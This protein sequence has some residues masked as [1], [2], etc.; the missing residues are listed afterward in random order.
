MNAHRP[1]RLGPAGFFCV[2]DSPGVELTSTG[3][4]P[5]SAR[6]SLAM[7][8]ASLT[9]SFSRLNCP[10]SP[11]SVDVRLKVF[12]EVVTP[13]GLVPLGAGDLDIPV[14]RL[15]GLDAFFSGTFSGSALPARP[16]R[17]MA[18][19][20]FEYLR[21][22]YPP[23]AINAPHVPVLEPP[24]RTTLIPSA[25]NALPRCT[26]PQPNHSKPEGEPF[27]ELT[28]R[29]PTVSLR[30]PSSPPPPTMSHVVVS[31]THPAAF[32]LGAGV[33]PAGLSRC[34]VIVIE[35]RHHVSSVGSP[36]APALIPPKT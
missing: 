3:A 30:P 34:H 21:P 33:T 36:A 10:S 12:D 24:T 17:L 6:R 31:T 35:L 23:N 22:S 11:P 1:L 13:L 8:R 4:M 9:L 20:P 2:E 16:G 25:A 15:L 28:S 14:S 7:R 27:A 29:R 5:S 26:S 19:T 18:W 32:V